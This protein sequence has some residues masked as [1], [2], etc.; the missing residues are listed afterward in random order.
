MGLRIVLA[1]LFLLPLSGQNDRRAPL[2]EPSISPDRSEIAFVSG[3]DIWTVGSA[4]GT[5]RLLVS[6]PATESRPLYSPDGT[7][8]AFTSTRTGNGDVYVVHLATGELKRLTF[9]EGLERADGWSADGKY[10]Y[11]SSSAT[12]IAAMAD[13]Q[14]VPVDGGS[15]M[16]YSGDRYA[17]EYF[18]APHP[19]DA[20]TI[21][22]TAK[23]VVFAQWWRNGHSHI[24]ESEIWLRRDGA[25]P[26]YERLSKGGAKEAWPMWS[27]DGKHLYYM[28][29]ASGAENLWTRP[30][31]AGGTPKQITTFK[32]GRVLWPSVSK[33]GKTIVFERDFGIWSLDTASGKAA[34]VKIA[35]R[36]T[37]AA[38]G[39]TRTQLTTGFGD[40]SLS[41]DGKKIAFIARGDVFASGAK[42]AGAATRITATAGLEESPR[43]A[44]D[45]K[46]LV[47][48]SDRDGASRLYLYDL[49][50]NAET[51]LTT[52]P[53]SDMS[54][55]WS[56][57]GKSIAFVRGAEKLM[58][59]DVESK[60]ERELA[61][62]YFRAQPLNSSGEIV[63][64]PDGKWIAYGSRGTRL[65]WNV[66][67]IPAAG[68]TPVQASYLANFGGGAITW[69]P[70]GKYI[71]FESGQRMED[72]KIARVDLIPRTPR[73][74][75]DQF[76][77][78]FKDAPAKPST[79]PPPAAPPTPPVTP[80]PAAGA[81]SKE[82]RVV[83]DGI[84]RRLTVLPAGVNANDLA[85]SP[86]G[87][88]L[89]ITG[90]AAGQ[91]NL[92]TYSLD[93]LARE[94]GGARQLTSTPGRK[95]EA[96]FTPD[97]KEVYFLEAGR[98][99]AISMDTR[100][101][102]PIAVSAEL[103]IDFAKDRKELFWQ[104][105]SYLNVHFYD[106]KFHGADWNATRSK[107]APWVEGSQT[108]DELRRVLSL[109][110]GELNASH[111][112][113]NGPLT[114]P[115]ATG[116]L[117]LRLDR[118]EFEGKGALKVTELISLSPAEVSGIKVGE[119]VTAVDG[120]AVNAKFSLAEALEYKSG[121]RVSLTVA[122]D[123]AGTGARDVP[124]SPVSGTQEK[125]L[126]YRHWV[127]KS[128]DYVHKV[129]NGRLGYVHM[130]DMSDASLDRLY[131]DLDTENVGR[132]G[133][134]VDI[135][136]N[137]G[138]FVNVYA[139]DVLARRPFLNMTFRGA[140]TIPARS[141]LGQRS[142]ERPTV[143]V[144]NQHSLSDAED[145]TEGYK[146]MKLGKVVGEP[147]AGWIIYTSNVELLD[148]S[149]LR[150]PGI[151]ITDA[152]GVNMERNPRT[153][154][155]PALRAVGESY[156]GKDTQLDAAVREL[157]KDL[158]APGK[159]G[160]ASGGQ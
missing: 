2:A 34:P 118:S 160:N 65:F 129:S 10:V 41:P 9:D 146:A 24:D 49:G 30:A 134:V 126:L 52:S 74:R 145:F 98:I 45:N 12:D 17:A 101:A 71:V 78:L 136:N 31:S 148:G 159:T 58:A 121:R 131:M 72:N 96:Q 62:G 23:G 80:A 43:W 157:L 61:G 76:R 151:K 3:G 119:Y 124:V 57:D 86:D 92:W 70:D 19:T 47:Y 153:V 99:Q 13:I 125:A 142:L 83:T 141:F 117:G 75:E 39:V 60:T 88:T 144:T 115:Q 20:S 51:Q 139:L 79:A 26:K 11:F 4:G 152:K 95:S 93:E 64:S 122:S 90:V 33:D 128:R 22:L 27:A 111:T 158:G 44:P 104:A 89:L 8:M 127:E 38:P 135:R 110:I 123:A 108:P 42:D 63:W 77:D 155:V 143:L 6:H 154:D 66:N 81:D 84:R 147:T 149:N 16:I 50:R 56:P 67:L 73:F 15:P 48:S 32:D 82:T 54:P 68:G 94:S 112:G 53:K 156:A 100:V 137:N 133:V 138:G 87:K 7:R 97:G 114:P 150:L 140:P 1:C 109:M 130:L 37:P 40:L 25:E 69:S 116:H 120:T 106:D 91:S 132:D 28:S 36:G 14:R 29:D 35:L 103:D 107:I 18:A 59:I 55:V 102:R 5:A 105:W 46:R 21:A 113:I 85:I